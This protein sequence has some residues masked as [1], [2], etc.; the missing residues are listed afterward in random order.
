MAGV[1]AAFSVL[2]LASG[3][4]R[5][6][7]RAPL[8]APIPRSGDPRYFDVWQ[9]ESGVSWMRRSGQPADSPVNNTHF[10]STGIT[11]I[12]LGQGVCAATGRR[13]YDDAVKIKYGNASDWQQ[14]WVNSTLARMDRWGFNTAGAWSY[15][16]PDVFANAR[17]H[18]AELGLTSAGPK[19]VSGG[20]LGESAGVHDF[21]NPE[22]LPDMYAKAKK[23]VLSLVNNTQ[24]IGYFF[25]NEVWWGSHVDEW[26]IV[27]RETDTMLLRYLN[28]STTAG[29]HQDAVAWLHE[30][31]NG[32]I[33][34]LN[35][36][37]N[38]NADSFDTIGAKLP[39]LLPSETRTKD[40]HAYMVGVATYFFAHAHAAIRMW[41]TNHLILGS[42]YSFWECPLEVVTA[43]APYTD[44]TSY[45]GY[46]WVPGVPITPFVERVHRASG[47]PLLISEFGFRA[48]ENLSDDWN[49]EGDAGYPVLT[50]KERADQYTNY[51]KDLMA[52]PWAVGF[53]E[54][55]LVDDPPHTCKNKGGNSNYGL[56]SATDEDYEL[57]QDH[58]TTV[59]TQVHAIHAAGK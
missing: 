37:W 57:F 26:P 2:P 55:K 32:S 28:L 16:F 12:H 25:S 6:Y 41:D 52:L 49:M 3:S 42:R 10:L 35:K 58:V 15:G 43:E 44:V 39:F 38:I 14:Q 31:Y 48:L 40:E 24:L 46:M 51:V 50:Q 22:F 36:A 1:V 8:P 4:Y 54:W 29:G 34:A 45:N 21:F 47:K 11:C 27:F 53:H 30:R 20:R 19:D 56:V 17:P 13:V 23:R 59:N 18:V 7:A 5:G 33:Q 9:D